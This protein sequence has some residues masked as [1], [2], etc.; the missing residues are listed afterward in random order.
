[1][2]L[3]FE[4]R[5]TIRFQIQEMARA[6]RIMSDSGIQTEL[7]VYNPLIPDPGELSATLYIELTSRSEMEEWLPKLVGIERAVQLEIGAV[8]TN[9]SSGGGRPVSIVRCDVDPAHEAALT[10]EELTAS[11]HYVRFSL[12]ATQVE[13]FRDEGV[14]VAID[15]PG[16]Q[17]R[18]P[19]PPETKSSLLEDLLA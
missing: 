6:E 1:V 7:D 11:V 17:E 15:H 2:S 18:T 8:G 13:R 19:L 10:R 5:D 4:N 16:Y 14:A 12:S 9:G 3:V